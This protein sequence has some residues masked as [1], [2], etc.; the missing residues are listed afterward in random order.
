MDEWAALN[1]VAATVAGVAGHD[2]RI[3]DLSP[4]GFAARA[5]LSRRTV[6]A[7]EAIVPFDRNDQVARDAMLERLRLDVDRYDTGVTTSQ[8]S[9][10]TGELHQLRTAFDLLQ[11]GGEQAAAA[12]AVRLGAVPAAL[13]QYQR[14]LLGAA[15]PGQSSARS[16]VLRV[17]AQCE[18]WA[19]PHGLPRWA[20]QIE[21][22][23]ALRAELS[24]GAEG[25]AAALAGLAD[26]LRSE[27]A[28]RSAASETIGPERYALASR[29]YL[30]AEI[31]L[32]EAY[33]WGFA[34]LRGLETTLRS[35]AAEIAGPGVGVGEAVAELNSDPGRRVSGTESFRDWMQDLVAKVVDQLDHAH[36]DIP[37]ELDTLEVMVATGRDGAMCHT[38]PSED[39]TRPGRLWWS[40]PSGT[41]SFS[42][43]QQASALHHYG[44]P[45]HSLRSAAPHLFPGRLN[46]WQ[47]MLGTVPGHAEGW[48][49]Y[50]ER[51]MAELGY[52]ADPG[53][54]M[55][56]LVSQWL[57]TTGLILDIGLHLK[58]EIPR[59]NAFG[60]HPGERW[61]PVL[62]REFLTHHG[63]IDPGLPAVALE[64]LLGRPG[65]APSFKIGERV[66]LAG[67]EEAKRR[68]GSAFNLKT[69]H[70]DAL[71]AG[72]L[73]L[74]PLRRALAQL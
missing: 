45:G 38:P 2:D 47:R 23:G 17:A 65:Q 39:R 62:V 13:R 46:R 32:H 37:R 54:R 3:D 26:F 7:L 18:R 9:A 72:P 11:A 66:W 34:E 10:V 60:F 56:L 8:I 68:N 29:Y 5:D 14:T 67:R 15:R 16:Q 31:D 64:S 42:T 33:E 40:V 35:T 57:R 12:I 73:G 70:R 44:V 43:W 69:F 6:A 51:L 21:A 30:G 53:D 63:R 41:E 59:D 74:D 58:L 24:R 55:G 48:A 1:P 52:L 27:L 25:A 50:A 61:K 20:E 4:D 49:L 19:G 36:F 28:P 22:E 71:K